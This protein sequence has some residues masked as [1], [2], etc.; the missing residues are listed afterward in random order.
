MSESPSPCPGCAPLRRV[1]QALDLAVGELA[2]AV[3]KSAHGHFGGLDTMGVSAHLDEVAD[4]LHQT[5]DLLAKV[6][7]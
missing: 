3:S 6:P 7:Q 5:S 1:V 2:L 4:L